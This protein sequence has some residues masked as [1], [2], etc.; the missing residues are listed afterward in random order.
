[1]NQDRDYNK[2]WY[3]VRDNELHFTHGQEGHFIYYQLVQNVKEKMAGW[4]E[5]YIKKA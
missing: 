4:I 2:G 3:Y 1:M 5:E